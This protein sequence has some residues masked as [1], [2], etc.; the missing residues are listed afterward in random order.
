VEIEASTVNEVYFR[1]HVGPGVDVACCHPSGLYGTAR[2][3]QQS[4]Q[5][6]PLLF[7][8]VGADGI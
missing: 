7:S 1:G 3:Q 8:A 4:C 6:E 2:G 5:G